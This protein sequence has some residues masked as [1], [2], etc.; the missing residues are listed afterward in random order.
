MQESND[1]PSGIRSYDQINLS[2]YSN[3]GAANARMRYFENVIM[4]VAD[5]KC[6][7][8]CKLQGDG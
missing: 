5:K 8:C 1:V 6:C 4:S 2:K 7:I 3:F